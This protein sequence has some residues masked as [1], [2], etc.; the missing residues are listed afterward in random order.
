MEEASASVTA[1][2]GVTSRAGARGGTAPPRAGVTQSVGSAL[3]MPPRISA[4]PA[5]LAEAPRVSLPGDHSFF[6]LISSQILAALY[7]Q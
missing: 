7:F 3:K 2:P 1:C 5:P 6:S 4:T